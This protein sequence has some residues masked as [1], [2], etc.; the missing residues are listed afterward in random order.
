MPGYVEKLLAKFDH[1]GIESMSGL[2]SPTSYTPPSYNKNSQ[3]P[4]L[5]D[6]RLLSDTEITTIQEIIGGVLYLCMSVR[7][8][9]ATA[10]NI[11][12][13][14]QSHPTEQVQAAAI[15]ILRYLKKHP[16]RGI[17]FYASDMIL[18]SYSDASYGSEPGF[19]SR[20]GGLYYFGRIN[21]PSF[22]N[23]PF[24]ILAAVQKTIAASVA[25]A[26]YIALFDNGQNIAAAKNT[27]LAMGYPELPVTI[28]TDNAFAV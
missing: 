27:L 26:E 25:E 13:C 8:D 20:S 11:V 7:P 28:Y 18:K 16:N 9:L 5:D 14:R 19:R 24:Q 12:D 6:S 23:A 21:D 17:K 1:L 2:D 4:F 22:I 15:L 3:V 10:I